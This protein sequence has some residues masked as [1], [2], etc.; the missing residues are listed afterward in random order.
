MIC[1]HC[2]GLENADKFSCLGLSYTETS[3]SLL[4]LHVYQP[5]VDRRFQNH[6]QSFLLNAL[7]LSILLCTARSH[8]VIWHRCRV[9][10]TFYTSDNPVQPKKKQRSRYVNPQQAWEQVKVWCSARFAVYDRAQKQHVPDLRSSYPATR[11]FSFDCLLTYTKSFAPIMSVA[12]KDSCVL[13]VFMAIIP[14]LELTLSKC[15]PNI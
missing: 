6:L 5:G 7:A 10:Y 14:T 8:A 9:S 3:C 4:N 12:T 15:T 13:S 11:L 1:F 2:E